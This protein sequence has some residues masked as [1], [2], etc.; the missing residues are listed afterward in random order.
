VR[1]LVQHSLATPRGWEELDLTPGSRKW[2]DLPKRPLPRGGEVLGNQRGWVFDICIQ[3]VCLRGSD[4]Y[5][6]EP[7]DDG[8]LRAYKWTDDLDD[9][10]T[11]YAF[12]Q[13]WTFY[14]GWVD[15]TL[16]LPGGATIRHR[17]PDQRLT[18]YAEDVEAHAPFTPVECGGLPVEL[19]PWSEFPI[20]DEALVRHGIWL[21]DELLHRHVAAQ[22]PVSWEAWTP[23]P[24]S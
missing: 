19:R 15:R 7:L 17:G 20:P 6:L 4:H 22:A 8:G 14:D 1:V 21:P 9:D 2:R 23:R 3:G 10:E 11:T 12:G 24:V 13:V 5:A 16:E 18:V